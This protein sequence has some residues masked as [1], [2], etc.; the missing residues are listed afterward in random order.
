L[1][2][3]DGEWHEI[4]IPVDVPRMTVR[5]L[6]EL[7]IIYI[8]FVPLQIVAAARIS[9]SPALST[10]NLASEVPPFYAGQP[11]SATMTIHT[12]FH[13]GSRAGDKEHKYMMRFDVEE[14]VRDWLVS[15]RKRGDFAAM[16]NLMF[17]SRR[18]I[19]D[20][21]LK[22]DKTYTV[23][24]TLIALHHGEVALPKVAVTALPLAGE[25]TMRSMAIPS[26]E[27]YQ[28]HGAEKVLVL[29]RGGRTTFAL[30]MGGS[31]SRSNG[32][33]N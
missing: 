2:P 12:S 3:Q 26:T 7:I 5:N 1:N 23:P 32:N 21:P 14:M 31:P 19:S 16:V 18:R 20:L 6:Y 28:L 11:I 4:M 25:I 27:T 10:D 8:N 17:F 15:G 24:I 33:I 22:D 13:W 9:L 30:S 29:P